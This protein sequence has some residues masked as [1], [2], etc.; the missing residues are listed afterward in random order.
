[1]FTELQSWET[2][3]VSWVLLVICQEIIFR[4]YNFDISH[5]LNSFIWYC[6]WI[7][8][9][10]EL[11]VNIWHLELEVHIC[12]SIKDLGFVSCK[13][14]SWWVAFLGAI[15]CWQ[16]L[17]QMQYNIGTCIQCL[18][19]PWRLN[20]TSVSCCTNGDDSLCF[21]PLNA[22]M[23]LVI[24]SLAQSNGFEFLQDSTFTIC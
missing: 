14:P 21:I 11:M 18:W 12:K 24:Y 5:V 2:Q 20:S 10:C 16:T 9:F 8:N 15:W 7:T 1:L 17:F 13:T 3:L 22:N 23:V 6:S 4:A 19:S